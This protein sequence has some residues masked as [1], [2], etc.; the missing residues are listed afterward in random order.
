[1]R[2]VAIPEEAS[3]DTDE[4]TLTADS[5]LGLALVGHQPGDT[6]TFSTPQGQQQVEL[7]A[8]RYPD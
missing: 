6:V 5:P 4:A 7:S 1:M 8:V 3:D 2:V